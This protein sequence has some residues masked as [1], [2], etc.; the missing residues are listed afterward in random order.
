MMSRTNFDSSEGINVDAAKFSALLENNGLGSLKPADMS[1]GRTPG[2]NKAQDTLTF[3]QIPGYD[4]SSRAGAEMLIAQSGSDRG[5][6]TFAA[7]Q[8]DYQRALQQMV[9]DGHHLSGGDLQ[10]GIGNILQNSG[11]S[12]KTWVCAEQAE[13]L[14]KV[15]SRDSRLSGSEVYLIHT[16]NYEHMF[17]GL[18]GQDGRMIYMDPW[19]E[20]APSYSSPNNIEGMQRVSF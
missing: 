11:L 18:K 5:A 20:K 10:S 13:Y 6:G 8:E 9:K 14:A 3:T 7:A 4:N 15:L 19:R 1:I 12:N 2:D 17:V 16:P